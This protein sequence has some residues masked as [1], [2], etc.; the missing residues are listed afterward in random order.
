MRIIELDVWYGPAFE[1][2]FFGRELNPLHS[3]LIVG[4]VKRMVLGSRYELDNWVQKCLP[5]K[6][7][8]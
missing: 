2:V 3:I 6:K 4:E 8:N 7:V 5:R 1:L